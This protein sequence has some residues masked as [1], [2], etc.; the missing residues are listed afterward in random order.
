MSLSARL[1]SA[2]GHF[3]SAAREHPFVTGIADGTLPRAAFQT[4]VAQDAFFLEAFARAYAFALAHAPDRAAI[5]GFTDLIVGV[6]D[7]LALHETYAER[8]HI[9]V[10]HVVPVQA[11]LDYTS[12]LLKAAARGDVGVTCAAMTPCMRLYAWLAQS[13]A[14]GDVAAPYAE[15]VAA[16]A[17]PEFDQ[18]ATRLEALLDRHGREDQA[19]ESAYDKAMHLE[20]A[21][22]DAALA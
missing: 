6:R 12:F 5:D 7:E 4:Y 8:W 1:W 17:S 19:T 2:N 11:T 16:Y 20:L 10:R 13:L 14:R 22:F 3:A 15:W 9:D 21:F 18:L